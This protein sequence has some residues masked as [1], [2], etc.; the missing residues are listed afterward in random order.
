[1][2]KLLKKMSALSVLSTALLPLPSYAQD[3]ERNEVVLHEKHQTL[4]VALNPSTVIC[5]RADYSMPMLKVLL[6]GLEDITLL[7]HQNRGAGAPCVTTGEICQFNPANNNFAKPD[8]IL[9]GRNG[10]E[11]IA[12]D[13]KVSRIEMIDHANK[14]CTVQMRETVDTEI[15]GK[16]LTHERVADLG[17]RPYTDC[18]RNP[19]K[20]ERGAL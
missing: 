12:V 5:S 14:V 6:P 1:M 4:T 3:F 8:D 16:K 17:D 10:D 18:V 20:S 7:D 13:V 9:Q 19:N 2:K 11:L 15:R